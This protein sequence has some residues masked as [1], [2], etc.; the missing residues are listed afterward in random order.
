MINSDLHWLQVFITRFVR[1]YSTFGLLLDTRKLFIFDNNI[2]KACS[3]FNYAS[4]D[5][6]I[7]IYFLVS[8]NPQ[9]AR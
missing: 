3:I 4:N 2:N 9:S 1:G 6:Y 5:V 7:Y 8:F